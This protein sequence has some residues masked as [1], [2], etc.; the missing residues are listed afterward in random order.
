MCR[1]KIKIHRGGFLLAAASS[2][3][4]LDCFFF[5]SLLVTDWTF[6]LKPQKFVPTH[7]PYFSH[8]NKRP[9]R[10]GGK[11]VRPRNSYFGKFKSP[12]KRGWA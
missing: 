11:G 1:K 4:I 7:R 6:C 2:Q 5:G 3:I 10:G 8:V 12:K 9:S